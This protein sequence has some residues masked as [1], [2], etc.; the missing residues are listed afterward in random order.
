VLAEY[1]RAA[2]PRVK[3]YA[4]A[5]RCILDDPALGPSGVVTVTSRLGKDKKAVYMDL[6]KLGVDK[7]LKSGG[8]YA[9]CTQ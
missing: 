2:T 3:I 9:Q 5:E 7:Q 4:E 1:L 6:V 8:A